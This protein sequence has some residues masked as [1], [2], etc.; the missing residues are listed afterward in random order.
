MDGGMDGQ[1]INFCILCLL[2]QIEK[3]GKKG[4]STVSTD[5]RNVGGALKD[6]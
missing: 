4:I 1:N 6:S 2:L 3:A 5:P